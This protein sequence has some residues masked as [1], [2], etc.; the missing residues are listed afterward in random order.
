MEYDVFLTF[1]VLTPPLPAHVAS[2]DTSEGC[3][4]LDSGAGTTPLTPDA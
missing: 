1:D 2:T 3:Y 4:G